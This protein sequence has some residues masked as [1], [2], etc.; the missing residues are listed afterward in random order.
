MKFTPKY[1]GER[2]GLTDFVD[3]IQ[4]SEPK[5]DFDKKVFKRIAENRDVLTNLIK[6][7]RTIYGVNTGMGGFVNYLIPEEKLGEL[8]INLLNGVATNVGSFLSDV[9]VRAAMLARIHSLAKGNSAISLENFKKL[10]AIFNAGILPCIPEK[11]SLGASGD[12][13]PLACIALVGIGKWK[14][15]YKGEIISGANALKIAQI[16]PMTLGFKEGL[17]LINGTSAMVG[18]AALLIVET[19]RLI[20]FYDVV[21]A[22]TLETLK[23][24][25]KPFDPRVHA[26]KP[27]RG[28]RIT[29]QNIFD[30]LSD[31]KLIVDEDAMSESL[32][33][34]KKNELHSAASQIEDAYSLRCT[35]QIIG[36]VRD[37]VEFISRIV[38]DELNSSNDNPLVITTEKNVFHNGHFHGQYISMAMDQL[39]I[40][41]TTLSNLSD[42]RIDRFLDEHNSNG[43]PPFLSTRPGLQFGLMG[44][45][46]MATSLTAENRSLCVPIS[47]QTLTSTGDFQDIVSFGLIAA[48]RVK[49]ILENLKYI[50]A[51]ELMCACQAADIRGAELLGSKTKSLF[52]AVREIVP[53]YDKDQSMTEHIELL[54]KQLLSLTNSYE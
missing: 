54:Q 36:P 44:G 41:L 28:Q 27:H 2:V 12:L 25:R 50:I 52:N 17:S 8:Q 53:F 45:Q 15:K 13:G 11:G 14:A 4:S 39:A 24:K 6:N 48:R 7:N 37:S 34:D 46:F 16:E 5:I 35:P 38:E 42:R 10:I 21:S 23:A 47:I 40:A 18:M 26:L 31:S 3:V 30:L 33:K 9:E 20:K 43:L 49:T 1:N 51:F 22:L 19:K 29:A 32:A